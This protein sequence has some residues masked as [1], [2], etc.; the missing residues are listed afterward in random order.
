MSFC[1][2]VTIL[3]WVVTA[4]FADSLPMMTAA[5]LT[6]AFSFAVFH[7]CCMRL[8][9]D[10]FSGHRQAAG[11]GLLYGFSSGVGGVLGAGIS[12]LAWET[13]GGRLAFTASALATTTAWLIY[14][15]RAATPTSAPV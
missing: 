3:R 11:Q 10:Y 2:A 15:R 13:G 5:Q 8:M 9:A 12:S 4:L 7:A 6:H 14:S 1:I